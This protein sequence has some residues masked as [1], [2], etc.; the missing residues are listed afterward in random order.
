[1]GI[2]APMHDGKI[3][4]SRTFGTAE[5]PVVPVSA[6]FPESTGSIVGP[7]PPSAGA[8]SASPHE[9]AWSHASGA[10]TRTNQEN[11]GRITS[12]V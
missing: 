11:R 1:M 7:V 3:G 4:G 12:T 8:V 6:F 10:R 9:A 5:S 2:E